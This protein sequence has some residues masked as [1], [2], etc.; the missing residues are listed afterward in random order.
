MKEVSLVY[1]VMKVPRAN[2]EIKGLREHQDPKALRV[3]QVSKVKVDSQA[4]RAALD[5]MVRR[6]LL[7]DQVRKVNLASQ[8]HRDLTVLLDLWDLLA[9]EVQQGRSVSQVKTAILAQSA[10]AVNQ[11][12]R[13]LLANLDAEELMD[14]LDLQV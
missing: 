14:R 8:V 13:A 7:E 11:D 6:V 12:L 3:S 4:H 2:E 10:K 9:Q 5:L 1:L